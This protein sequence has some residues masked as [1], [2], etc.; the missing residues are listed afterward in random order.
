VS[1]RNSCELAVLLIQKGINTL[2]KNQNHLT[3]LDLAKSK[4]MKEILGYVPYNWR[5][6]EGILLKKRSMRIYK[7]RKKIIKIIIKIYF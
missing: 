4:E 3:A 5:K 1:N 6:Y 7:E 2:I